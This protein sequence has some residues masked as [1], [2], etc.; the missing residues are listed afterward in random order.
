MPQHDTLN[1][2]T[3][4]AIF[5]NTT[6]TGSLRSQRSITDWTIVWVDEGRLWNEIISHENWSISSSNNKLTSVCTVANSIFDLPG[7]TFFHYR[8]SRHRISIDRDILLTI[9]IC[10]LLRNTVNW[11]LTLIEFI[12]KKLNVIF[13][14][15]KI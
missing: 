14:V 10:L 1:I 5:V 8:K 9:Y 3:G 6:R 15:L 11:S 13:G 7:H 4:E 2:P 12:P